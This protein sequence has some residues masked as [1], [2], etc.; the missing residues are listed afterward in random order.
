MCY[1]TRED[2]YASLNKKPRQKDEDEEEDLND[3]NYDEVR[4]VRRYRGVSN[5][6]VGKVCN[7]IKVHLA[8][9]L[10]YQSSR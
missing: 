9:G 7:A 3:A 2:R 8:D 1:F 10:W 5:M 6:H 4:V